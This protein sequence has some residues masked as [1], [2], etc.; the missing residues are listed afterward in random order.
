[1]IGMIGMKGMIGMI[2]M[3]SRFLKPTDDRSPNSPP[4][5]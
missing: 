3:I 5:A 1:M 4:P 2:G